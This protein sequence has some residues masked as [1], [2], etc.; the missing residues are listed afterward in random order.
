MRGQIFAVLR[1]P[2]GIKG[3]LSL[4]DER[5]SQIVEFAVAAPILIVFVVGIFDFSGALNLKQKISNA[6]QS[7]ANLAANQTTADLNQTNAASIIAIRDSIF[8]YLVNDKILVNANVG[9]CK[10]TSAVLV[11][12]PNSLMWQYTIHNCGVVAS[13]DLVI[14]IDRGNVFSSGTENV[15][16]SHVGLTYPYH[17]L[18]NRVIQL[19][20]P[21]VFPG[22]TQIAGD[23]ISQ[24]MS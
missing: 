19:V 7:G 8:D 12:A 17:W 15:A 21:A 3:H 10:A 22:T 13:D 23:S 5:A 6:A 11:H 9:S 14:T 4:W 2:A 18:F 24:N 16:A 20:A 1:Q